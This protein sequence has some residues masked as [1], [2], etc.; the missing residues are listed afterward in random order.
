MR[1]ATYHPMGIV[2]G[3]VDS[4]SANQDPFSLSAKKHALQRASSQQRIDHIRQ[5]YGRFIDATPKKATEQAEAVENPFR[6]NSY[7]ERMSLSVYNKPKDLAFRRPLTAATQHDL[8]KN[9]P[10]YKPAAAAVTIG[11]DGQPEALPE[12]AAADPI[13][14]AFE[15]TDKFELITKDATDAQRQRDMLEVM[16]INEELV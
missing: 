15:G 4:L 16:S 5:H 7:H 13:L 8:L 6:P 14:P 10:G 1:V 11:A 12:V 2:E 3:Y 9:I